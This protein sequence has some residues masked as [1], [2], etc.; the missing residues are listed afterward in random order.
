MDH[1]CQEKENFS[2]ALVWFHLYFLAQEFWLEEILM[3]LGSTLGNYVTYFEATKQRK[4]TSYAR[5]CVYMNISKALPDTFTLEY[6][7]EEWAKTIV[8]E[9]IPFICRKCHEHG[10][11]FRD[12]PLNAPPP[13]KGN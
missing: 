5:M 8:Y 7:D 1:L 9:H 12:C 6:Q 11:L 10:H 4:Y 13:P 3:G 2:Y